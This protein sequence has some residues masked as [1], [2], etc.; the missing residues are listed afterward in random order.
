MTSIWADTTP[1]LSLDHV[2]GI[3]PDIKLYWFMWRYL[4]QPRDTG[5]TDDRTATELGSLRLK[6]HYTFDYVFSSRFYETL[7]KLILISP[8]IKVYFIFSY[9]IHS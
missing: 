1:G 8:E 5:R 3:K 6:I 9:Y 4:L 2:F 7:R